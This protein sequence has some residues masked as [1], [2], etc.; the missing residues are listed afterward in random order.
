MWKII[1][2]NFYL[3]RSQIQSHVPESV[4]LNCKIVEEKK[5]EK[6]I[7]YK[8]N[9]RKY[10]EIQKNDNFCDPRATAVEKLILL[11]L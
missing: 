9:I 8:N 3:K 10:K 1:L 4:V 5:Y 7:K 6:K 2:L 11:L